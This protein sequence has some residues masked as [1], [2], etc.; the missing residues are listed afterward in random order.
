LNIV[1]EL[2]TGRNEGTDRGKYFLLNTGIKNWNQL[3]A[4]ALEAY[5]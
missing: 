3:T 5:P 1:G 4:K 2:G